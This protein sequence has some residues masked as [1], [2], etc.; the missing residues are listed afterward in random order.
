[1]TIGD[2][3]LAEGSDECSGQRAFGKQVT[4]QVGYAER[5]GEG[6]HE[7]ATTEQRGEDL[8]ADETQY[9]AAHDSEADD[10]RSLGVEF[11]CGVRL[12]SR[13]FHALSESCLSTNGRH[14]LAVHVVI[15]LAV[16]GNDAIYLIRPV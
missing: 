10:A 15:T 11:L 6:I 9:A 2:R 16:D 14:I 8:F 3:G 12:G 5:S 4:Q 13:L 1:M 7:A